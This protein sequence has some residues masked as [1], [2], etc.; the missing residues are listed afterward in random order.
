[1]SRVIA[2]AAAAIAVLVAVLL[3]TTDRAGDPTTRLAGHDL[4]SAIDIV[5][6]PPATAVGFDGSGPAD[7]PGRRRI[8]LAFTG[9]LLPH[10]PVS[11]RAAA[12]AGGQGY[13][14]DPMFAAVTPILEEADLAL[15]HLESPISTSDDDV[16][17]Y[18]T[19]NAPVQLATAIAGAGWDG[20]ST[21]SNH[22]WDRGRRGV[23]DTITVLTEAGVEVAGTADRPGRGIGFHRRNGLRIAHLSYTYGL[24][25]FRL[26]ADEPWLVNLIDAEEIRADA[27]LARERGADIVVVSLHWGSEYVTEPTAAQVELIDELL[28]E[29]AIDLV[30]GHHA[31]VVQP[32]DRRSGVPIV[33]GLGNFL[34]NQSAACCPAATQDGVIM[35]VTLTEGER[36]FRSAVRYVPTYVDRSTFTVLPV[37]RG[38]SAGGVDPAVLDASRARTEAAVTALGADEWGVREW[39][40]R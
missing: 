9:D 12:L 4:D 3:L 15:C 17:G 23:V 24:N 25:G 14:F 22:S 7:D 8:T 13:D 5:P 38:S 20:C 34:S 10:S 11:A 29:P 28:P 37:H 19:F 27:G 2:L 21:A 6:S 30:V 40:P 32:V 31:H 18:P 33:Y 35:L 16:T 1:M 26:P 39:T 36:R